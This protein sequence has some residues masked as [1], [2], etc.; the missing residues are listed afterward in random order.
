MLKSEYCSRHSAGMEASQ[1]E[2]QW[3]VQSNTGLSNLSSIASSPAPALLYIPAGHLMADS[4]YQFTCTATP[5]SVL[6]SGQV[7]AAPS[8]RLPC[9]RNPLWQAALG[10]QCSLP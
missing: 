2:F 7:C 3:G 8:A 9:T 4:Q 6:D 10:L 1:S 5:T